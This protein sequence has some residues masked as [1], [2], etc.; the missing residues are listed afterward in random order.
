MT[1]RGCTLRGFFVGI[2]LDSGSNHVV[3]DNRIEA[4]TVV[5][6][7]AYSESGLV[8]RNVVVDSGGGALGYNVFAISAADAHVLDNTVSGVAP[9]G[10]GNAVGL[11]SDSNG[12]VV[13]SGNRIT[14]LVP[15]G[16]GYAR[17]I[18]IGGSPR[19]SC[20]TS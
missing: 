9:T 4:A 14:G 19:R 12:G 11:G 6:I 5:G 18:Q 17:G 2:H 8:Q 10:N 16:I 15:A 7:G 1:I 3:E 20:A 13:V